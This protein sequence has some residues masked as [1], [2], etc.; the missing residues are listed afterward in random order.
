MT[1]IK[2]E[3][4]A[5]T[6]AQ[7]Q[8]FLKPKQVKSLVFSAVKKTTSQAKAIAAKA[9][10]ERVTVPR[11]YVDGKNHRR[12]A[13]KSSMAG[14]DIPVGI[15]KIRRV[16]LPMSAFK[17]KASKSA[18][19]S[20]T[21][22]K[23]KS[24]VTLRHAFVA[25]VSSKAQDEQEVFHKGVFSRAARKNFVGGG[26][27]VKWTP[28]GY[29]WRLPIK[30]HFGPTI[31]DFITIPEIQARVM[32]DI[33]GALQKNIDSQISRFTGGQFKSL[34]AAISAMRMANISENEPEDFEFEQ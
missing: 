14:G 9:V 13:I 26:E 1:P 8:S 17:V 34:A 23:T 21:F 3:I 18:G 19:V 28:A 22:D 30:E 32:R 27:K 24:P 12:A 5:A 4:D 25:N 20:V 7:L 33:A 2:F 29:A 16:A 10:L 15:V 6:L 31:L 11:R